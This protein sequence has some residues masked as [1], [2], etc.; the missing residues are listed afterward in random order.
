MTD[1]FELYQ[2]IADR[3]TLISVEKSMDGLI[4]IDFSDDVLDIFCSYLSS[5]ATQT[6][7]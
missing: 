4:G 7:Q 3:Q 1:L 5:S 6:S 2:A